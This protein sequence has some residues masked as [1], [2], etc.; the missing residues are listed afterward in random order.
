VLAVAGLVSFLRQT[1]PPAPGASPTPASRQVESLARAV[2]DTQVELARKRLEAGD[3]AEALRQAERAM[4]LDPNN[5]GATEIARN[6]R[7]AVDDVDAAVAAARNAAASGNAEASATALWK[8][9]QVAPDHALVA[10][11]TPRLEG[12]FRSRAEEARRSSAA[13]RRTSEAAGAA[14]LPAFGEAN[15][16]VREGE[17]ALQAQRFATAARAFLKA[18]ERFERAQRSIR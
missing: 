15:G 14:Q 1:P 3:H 2:A 9:L 18:Q 4:K 6:A 13:A 16:L 17:N 5:A 11:L 8:L 10:E 7:K 12:S